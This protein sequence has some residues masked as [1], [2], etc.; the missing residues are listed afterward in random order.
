MKIEDRHIEWAV[1]NRLKAMLD[2]PPSLALFSAI[3][4][5]TK[6]RAWVG[7]DAIDRAEWFSDADHAARDVRE[8]LRAV[9]IFDPPWSLSRSRPR[10]GRVRERNP[11]DLAEEL[12]NA[13]FEGVTAEQFVKWLRDAL[14]HG[15]ASKIRPI[16][17]PSRTGDET[18]LAGFEI[19][20]PAKKGS[21][22]NLTL[23][24]YH[25]DMTQIGKLLAGTFCKALSGGDV[26]FEREADAATI[27]EAA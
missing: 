15:D 13:D 11:I 8:A 17:R 21:K 2:A 1:V 10:F 7:G 25:A 19:E 14:A 9:S 5:W 24:L 20:S 27:T 12:I 18:F 16:H 3:V 4:L 6:L 23:S 22:R 26:G